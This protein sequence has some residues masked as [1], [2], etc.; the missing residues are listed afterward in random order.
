MD[1]WLH[2]ERVFIS[3]YRACG[4]Y[5]STWVRRVQTTRVQYNN[6]FRLVLMESKWHHSRHH[7]RENSWPLI[8][9][10]SLTMQISST[11]TYN[12]NTN[13]AQKMADTRWQCIQKNKLNSFFLK[14]VFFKCIIKSRS[15][16]GPNCIP[17]F[18]SCLCYNFTLLPP[19]RRSP[20]ITHLSR[21]KKKKKKNPSTSTP[22]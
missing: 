4:R 6:T 9:I 12:D 5:L 3:R 22:L 7:Y 13:D 20:F 21:L 16:V 15:I 2:F 18:C 11:L 8:S 17:P 1:D 14:R 19:L 10:P